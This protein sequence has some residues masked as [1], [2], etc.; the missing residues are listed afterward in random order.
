MK[1]VTLLKL[2]VADVFHRVSVNRKA[3]EDP[4]FSLSPFE[5]SLLAECP[6]ENTKSSVLYYSRST[7]D[8]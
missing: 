8:K 4:H 1:G 2:A 6:L 3:E 5:V 7:R